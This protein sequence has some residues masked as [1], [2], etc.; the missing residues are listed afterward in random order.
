MILPAGVRQMCG[1]AYVE[2]EV[3]PAIDADGTP[4]AWGEA[5]WPE[6]EKHRTRLEAWHRKWGD[7]WAGPKDVVAGRRQGPGGGESPLALFYEVPDTNDISELLMHKMVKAGFSTML[8]TAPE[9]QYK[10]TREL[11]SRLDVNIPLVQNF[12]RMLCKRTLQGRILPWL[13]TQQGLVGYI[14][15]HSGSP[16]ERQ[17]MLRAAVRWVICQIIQKRQHSAPAYGH[18][19]RIEQQDVWAQQDERDETSQRA[20][21][22]PLKAT[23]PRVSAKDRS[24]PEGREVPLSSAMTDTRE[25]PAVRGPERCTA[26]SP[27]PKA[28]FLLGDQRKVYLE[29]KR[30]DFLAV[31]I[32]YRCV[33]HLQKSHDSG[34]WAAV[35]PRTTPASSSSA[36][37]APQTE[38]PSR[39]PYATG[40]RTPRSVPLKNPPPSTGLRSRL[41]WAASLSADQM[42]DDTESESEEH[43]EW[44]QVYYL[45]NG[46]PHEANAFVESLREAGEF[47][48]P[49]NVVTRV[50]NWPQTS[51]VCDVPSETEFS[52]VIYLRPASQAVEASAV[53]SSASSWAQ[54]DFDFAE[55]GITDA[56]ATR[57][58]SIQMRWSLLSSAYESQLEDLVSGNFDLSV[59]PPSGLSLDW[60]K[61]VVQAAATSLGLASNGDDWRHAYG[62]HSDS[63]ATGAGLLP[64]TPRDQGDSSCKVGIEGAVWSALTDEEKD[65]AKQLGWREQADDNSWLEGE[66]RLLG[67]EHRDGEKNAGS[68][69]T[70]AHPS[71]PDAAPHKADDDV[72]VNQLHFGKRRAN[73]SPDRPDLIAAGAAGT[74][75]Q[76]R[77]DV[78][79]VAAHESNWLLIRI[80]VGTGCRDSNDPGAESDGTKLRALPHTQDQN[81]RMHAAE[82]PSLSD[83][84]AVVPAATPQRIEEEVRSCIIWSYRDIAERRLAARL[85]KRGERSAELAQAQVNAEMQVAER[86]RVTALLDSGATAGDFDGVTLGELASAAATNLALEEWTVA[87]RW[88]HRSILTA[89]GQL[90][91]SRMVAQEKRSEIPAEMV[92][93]V[94]NA[95]VTTTTE[96]TAVQSAASR[97]PAVEA[98]RIADL[99]LGPPGANED[100]L[101][102][103][104]LGT[105]ALVALSDIATKEIAPYI[106][107]A[108]RI[109]ML[110][111]VV[112]LIIPA[113]FAVLVALITKA[114]VIR[115]LD[116]WDSARMT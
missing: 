6:P 80:D 88:F 34:K 32:F 84:L 51:V 72:V 39:R 7:R 102:Q 47:S 54:G 109:A 106:S 41:W 28:T 16:E 30:P 95:A 115:D 23:T 31:R 96:S 71:E 85:A 73:N 61:H 76:L 79:E 21:P 107:M 49:E 40:L 113:M 62:A 33:S 18:D 78:S 91:H 112:A 100:A 22:E 60:D 105:V 45:G 101:L 20:S 98:A 37:A 10:I 3:A 14:L 17:A 70:P 66:T 46:G 89:L 25:T 8:R 27:P 9:M 82:P 69:Q 108:R 50:V 13:A 116:E 19:D 38:P 58:N 36:S 44:N 56:V 68:P 29:R 104:E 86:A 48:Q 67:N 65:A 87:A 110:L 52:V 42:E 114:L 59:L 26:E 24:A 92:A 90:Y 74:T 94:A 4:I 93:T 75:V 97:S 99:L 2:V 11:S 55:H 81:A 57:L 43:E 35:S 111:G 103:H 63:A 64:F 1:Q 83:M 77:L 12:A 5:A 15:S 53:A